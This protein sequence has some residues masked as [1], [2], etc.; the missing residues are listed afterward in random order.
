MVTFDFSSVLEHFLKEFC[1][2]AHSDFLPT[3]QSDSFKFVPLGLAMSLISEFWLAPDPR[4]SSLLLLY[5]DF[6]KFIVCN[7]I[8]FYAVYMLYLWDLYL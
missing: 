8:T 6:A 7:L 5:R 3:L 4:F 1:K 2:T